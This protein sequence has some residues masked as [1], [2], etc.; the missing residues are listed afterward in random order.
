MIGQLGS[1]QKIVIANTKIS[2]SHTLRTQLIDLLVER[3]TIKDKVG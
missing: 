3:I 1:E 2:V